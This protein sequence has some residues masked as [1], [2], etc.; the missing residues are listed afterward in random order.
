MEDDEGR[1][2]NSA[3]KMAADS[4][5]LEL[6][7]EFFVVCDPV[8]P[9]VG[10]LDSADNLNFRSRHF[11]VGSRAYNLTYVVRGSQQRAQYALGCCRRTRGNHRRRRPVA[12]NK[13]WVSDNGGKV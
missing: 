10:K 6:L 11:F 13:I 9:V 8:E 1:C 2:G 3:G 5:S 4:G 12:V 7:D